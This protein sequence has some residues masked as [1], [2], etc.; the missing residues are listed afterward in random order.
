MTA[1][2]ANL[3]AE[4][5]AI[6]ALLHDV[7]AAEHPAARLI[8]GH[9]KKSIAVLKC[10]CGLYLLPL[11]YKAILYHKHPEAPKIAGNVLAQ[12]LCFADESSA[13]NTP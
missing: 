6:V 8:N 12:R 4:S 9:G 7:A 1:E 11:E 5:V 10:L 13:T 2:A 3:P